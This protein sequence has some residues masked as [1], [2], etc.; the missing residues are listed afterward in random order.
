MNEW[1]QLLL[2]GS[3]GSAGTVIVQ[4][5]RSRSARFSTERSID[6]RLQEHWTDT[7]LKLVEALQAELHSSREQLAEQR[8]GQARLAHFEEALDHIHALLAALKSVNEQELLAAE[9]RASAFLRRMRPDPVE[10]KGEHRQEV[11]RD[12]SA[13][14]VTP[15]RA[16]ARKADHERTRR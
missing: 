2:A 1:L 7:T 9:R 11:Q 13:E 6:A 14:R 15:T 16:R 3:A 5:L 8:L 4:M 10:L 12:I